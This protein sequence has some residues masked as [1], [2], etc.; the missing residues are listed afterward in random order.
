MV[1]QGARVPEEVPKPSIGY[2]PSRESSPAFGAVAEMVDA[3]MELGVG[4]MARRV[5]G[6]NPDK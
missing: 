4:K 1:H 6:G 2:V 5:I 3:P